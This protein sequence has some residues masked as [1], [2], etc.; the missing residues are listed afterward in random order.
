MSVITMAIKG[1]LFRYPSSSRCSFTDRPKRSGAE[2]PGL[3]TIATNDCA[4]K[5]P[6]NREKFSEDEER[7]CLVRVAGGGER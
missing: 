1:S 5:A 7:T 4:R 3:R 2:N 6:Q